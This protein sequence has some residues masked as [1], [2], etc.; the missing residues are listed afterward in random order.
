M[1]LADLF[2]KLG[3]NKTDYEKGLN[4]AKSQT[5]AFG[6]AI[7]KLGGIIAGVFAVDKLISFGKEVFNI[8][9]Q[10]QGIQ[11]AFS[12]IGTSGDLDNL[13]NSVKGTVS[14]LE[15]MKRAVMASNF[16]IPVQEL[17][18]LF[19]FAAKR[20]QDTG[21]SIDYLVDSIV[22]GIGRKSPLIL[23]NLGISAVQLREK[24]KGVGMETASVADITSAV[25]A[26]AQ[27]ALKATGGLA[28]NLGT[29]VQ[30]L[31]ASWEN[32][33]LT[34]SD[35]FSENG[36]L[37]QMLD[38][39]TSMLQTWSNKNAT[40]FQKFMATFAPDAA[41]REAYKAQIAANKIVKDAIESGNQL[42]EVN[43]YG[44]KKK[45]TIIQ[46]ATEQLAAIRKV[47]DEL[48]AQRILRKEFYGEKMKQMTPLYQGV[49]DLMLPQKSTDTMGVFG[50][51]DSHY[52]T[53]SENRKKWTQEEL[54]AWTDFN[55]ELN[56]TLKN[57]MVDA[58]TTLAEGL[59][60]LFS[61]DINIGEFGKNVL[62]TIGRFLQTLGALM[63]AYG[64]A[65]LKFVKALMAGPTPL[66]AG[67]A[68]A[69]GVGLVAAGA[70][71]ASFSKKGVSGYSTASG[72]ASGYTNYSA[73]SGMNAFDGNVTF[74]LQ[75]T[76]LVGVLNNTQ[77]KTSISK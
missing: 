71:V 77:R 53:I 18:K 65:N 69:A 57:G 6:S 47:N 27:D 42:Q 1:K 33:K 16:G 36:F 41:I 9:T 64:I 75:G 39:A 76:K 48:E 50:N 54:Q 11:T 34:L 68:I 40:I 24:L 4:E 72:S 26:I 8:A 67:L 5:S 12:K 28:D 60:Q 19:E 70:A 15:L 21:Q 59:G 10:A 22:I 45:D 38:G 31:S 30:T 51:L 43:V 20:A 7:G 52:K 66:G 61:G 62:S 46:T 13:R 55:L 14:D 58:V 44:K 35:I 23:D 73:S 32:F 37:Q 63:I 56:D 3:L 74:E 29:K 2:I 49:G 17:G 25:G